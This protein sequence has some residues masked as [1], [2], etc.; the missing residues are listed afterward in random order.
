MI[1]RLMAVV[2]WDENENDD[3]NDFGHNN[4]DDV[5]GRCFRKKLG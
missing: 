5:V 3:N 1:L 2:D 4:D